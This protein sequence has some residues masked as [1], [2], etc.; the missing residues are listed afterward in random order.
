MEN[1]QVTEWVRHFVR[2]QVKE[3]DLC[4]DATMGNGS[5]TLLLARLA[6]PDG[7]VMAF[8][9]QEQALE[10]TA[11]RLKQEGLDRNCTLFLRSHEYMAC[12][13]EE[14][15]VSCIVFNLGYLPGGSHRTSTTAE[16]TLRAVQEGLRL[17]KKNGLM[18]ICI[19]S[20]GDTGFEEK[21]MI[22]K[23]LKKLDE[24]EYL[25]ILNCFYNRKNDPPMPVFVVKK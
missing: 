3:G 1:W 16:T 9:I 12:C 24:K 10:N 22:L 13:A 2:E 11:R 25:V 17:L 21:D 14:E 18:T 8:D 4:I 15:S 7:H 20:G 5:D 19:Y 23:H 6:G